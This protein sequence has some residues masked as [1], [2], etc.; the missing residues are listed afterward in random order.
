[1]RKD[2]GTAVT[3]LT[4]N[5]VVHLSASAAT[6]ERFTLNSRGAMLG[7]MMS[8]EQL[9]EGRM[10]IRTPVEGLFLTGHWTRPGG[11]ITPVIVSALHAAEAVTGRR[12]AQAAEALPIA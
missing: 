9:G 8:P 6:S 1:M 7:W 5:V 11:G 4:A 10:G 12:L 2:S 3:P